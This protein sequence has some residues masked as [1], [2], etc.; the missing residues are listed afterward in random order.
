[1]MEKEL[2]KK[3]DEKVGEELEK[4]RN[5]DPFLYSSMESIYTTI[6]KFR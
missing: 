5:G 6:N 2:H 4:M 1:M 3:V